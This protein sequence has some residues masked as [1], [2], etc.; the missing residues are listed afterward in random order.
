[1]I[2]PH[3]D[4]FPFKQRIVVISCILSALVAASLPDLSWVHRAMAPVAVLFCFLLSY[5]V[6]RVFLVIL[7]IARPLAVLYGFFVFYGMLMACVTFLVLFPMIVFDP[8]ISAPTDR[9]YIVVS[10]VP[11]AMGACAAVLAVFRR[12]AS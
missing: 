5:F 4:A 7:G 12:W 9:E 10:T 8:Q 3:Q 11:C 1:M 2:W 6:C